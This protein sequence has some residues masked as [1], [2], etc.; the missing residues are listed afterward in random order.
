MSVSLSRQRHRRDGSEE[1][2]RNFRNFPRRIVA[3]PASLACSCISCA[4]VF[5]VDSLSNKEMAYVTREG[6]L[7]EELLTELIVP[8]FLNHIIKIYRY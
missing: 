8:G 3:C 6:Y 1:D 2:F 4:R 5:R 7:Q